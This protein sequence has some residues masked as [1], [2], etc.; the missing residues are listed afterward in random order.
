M[1]T[2]A[3]NV[4]ICTYNR[5][6]KLAKVLQSLMAAAMPQGVPVDIIVVDNNSSDATRQVVTEF[7]GSANPKLRY[8]FEA[9]QGKS[10]ALNTAL[11]NLS[12]DIVAF[13]DD[14]V[15]VD[16][17]FLTEICRAAQNHPGVSCFGGRVDAI[18]P[19]AAPDWM[20]LEGSMGFLKSALL[21]RDDGDCEAFYDTLSYSNTPAGCNMFFRREA[22]EKNG[23]FRTDLGPRGRQFGFAEDTEYCRRL[24]D[25]GYRFFYIPTVIIH[26]PIDPVRLTKEYLSDWQYQCGKS[27][28]LSSADIPETTVFGIP[29]YLFRKALSHLLGCASADPKIRAF[30]QL[31]LAYS[32]GQIAG[33]M[34]R[35]A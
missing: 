14:D 26:H 7:S 31:R 6:E 28:A 25:K 22:L 30:H 4:V 5:A 21:D 2:N 12:A 1:N 16:P 34:Q 15:I 20:D 33:F 3:L 23:D 13:T 10:Y 35:Q 9:K 19:E 11:G 27:E 32:R 17:G 29:R 24:I 8:I 18:Y